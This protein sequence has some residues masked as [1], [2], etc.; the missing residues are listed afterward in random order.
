[1]HCPAAAGF[2]WAVWEMAGVVGGV[3]MC[4]LFGDLCTHVF[5]LFSLPVVVNT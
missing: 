5:P 2:G 4:C 1:M 3:Q